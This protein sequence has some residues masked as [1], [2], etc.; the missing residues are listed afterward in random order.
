MSFIGSG[1]N[2]TNWYTIEFDKKKY[3]RFN[4]SPSTETINF[5]N[6]DKAT[7]LK[8]CALL[9]VLIEEGKIQKIADTAL[10][11]LF[12]I[13]FKDLKDNDIGIS[14]N[15]RNKIRKIEAAE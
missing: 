4:G 3:T 12:L 6:K 8:F 15:L 1:E 13:E 5:F 10:Q 11:T 2:R 9:Q 14:T 7:I